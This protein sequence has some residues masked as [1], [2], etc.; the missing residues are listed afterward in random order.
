MRYWRKC[1]YTDVANSSAFTKLLVCMLL[2]KFHLLFNNSITKVVLT[3]A[4]AHKSSS[5]TMTTGSKPNTGCHKVFNQAVSFVCWMR[6]LIKIYHSK[7]KTK[8]WTCTDI[9]KTNEQSK[10]SCTVHLCWLIS[11]RVLALAFLL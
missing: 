3:F 7:I 4:S 10:R 9:Q 6:R 1:I 8:R 5:A 11:L 2:N